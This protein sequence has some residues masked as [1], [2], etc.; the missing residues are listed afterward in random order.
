[1]WEDAR[2]AFARPRAAGVRIAKVQVSAALEVDAQVDEIAALERFDDG[3]YLHQAVARDGRRARD[4][5]VARA[6]MR[7]DGTT[8]RV[9]AHVPIFVASIE[10]F[11]STQACLRDVLAASLE[12]GGVPCYEVETYTW[13]VLPADLRSEN[14][15]RSIA[16]ELEWARACLAR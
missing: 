9:H 11:R 2:A 1:M 13:N 3:V 10:P 5:D 14:V 12:D 6:A 7:A 8:W 4:L 16:R 15:A